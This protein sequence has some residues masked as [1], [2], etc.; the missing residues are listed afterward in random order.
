M[1]IPGSWTEP[2]S[3]SIWRPWTDGGSTRPPSPP[4]FQTSQSVST[5]PTGIAQEKRYPNIAR[6]RNGADTQTNSSSGTSSKRPSSFCLQPTEKTHYR[7]NAASEEDR[8]THLPSFPSPS[9]KGRQQPTSSVSHPEP[10]IWLQRQ[11]SIA[12]SSGIRKREEDAIKIA[13][14]DRDQLLREIAEIRR[15][16]KELKDTLA[17]KTRKK[18]REMQ[19]KEVNEARV[20]PP[21]KIRRGKARGWITPD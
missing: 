11:P 4:D 8:D 2:F 20:R 13:P 9:D 5:G 21:R 18:E 12:D 3:K 1:S 14:Y 10:H 16:I 17:T 7:D 6:F 19:A 15:G